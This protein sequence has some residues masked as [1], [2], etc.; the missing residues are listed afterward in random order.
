MKNHKFAPKPA[1]AI[2]IV[3]VQ[4]ESIKLYKFFDACLTK[5][6]NNPILLHNISHI[7]L[8]TTKQ[9]KDPKSTFVFLKLFRAAPCKLAF[10]TQS[11]ASMLTL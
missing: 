7:F 11:F 10:I 5:F 1:K 4:L 3:S 9:V 6:K 2:D 8:Q